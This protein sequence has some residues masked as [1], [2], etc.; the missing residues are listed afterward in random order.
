MDFKI[1]RINYYESYAIGDLNKD[2]SQIFWSEK[3]QEIKREEPQQSRSPQ[4]LILKL[5]T[6]CGGQH[7]SFGKS[8]RILGGKHSIKTVM[9]KIQ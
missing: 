1:H 8:I 4:G 3:V 7:I 5:F 6:H 2:E 9:W